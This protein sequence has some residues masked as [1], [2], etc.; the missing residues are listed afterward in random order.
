MRRERRP[1]FLRGLST[2]RWSA[3]NGWEVGELK[4]LTARI[5]SGAAEAVLVA[6][7]YAPDCAT[8]P[9][10]KSARWVETRG[11]GLFW[12][13]LRSVNEWVEGRPTF[14]VGAAWR[15]PYAHRTPPSHVSP[16][17]TLTPEQLFALYEVLPESDHLDRE[18]HKVLKPLLAWA[19]ANPRLAGSYPAD[20]I[21]HEAFLI[22]EDSRVRNTVSPLAGTYRL[23]ISVRG[24]EPLKLFISTARKPSGAWYA[25]RLARH[26]SA[27]AKPER[28]DGYLLWTYG[29]LTEPG[30]PHT[31]EEARNSP[32]DVGVISLAEEAV[33]TDVGTQLWRGEI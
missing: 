31:Y 2:G 4:E 9:W 6:W 10:L 22:A 17:S 16:G 20:Q 26:D 30:I 8:I 11:R 28:A 27:V 25:G 23:E 15:Q 1:R 12:G 13:K 5:R 29:G 7:G 3:S 24:E 14:D 33:V 21:L 32:C 19:E 18:P